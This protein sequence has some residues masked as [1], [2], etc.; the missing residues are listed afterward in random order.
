MS[1]AIDPEDLARS[2]HEAYERLAPDH[3]YSTREESRLPWADVPE[4]NK[5]LMIAVCTELGPLFRTVV[6]ECCV[7]SDALA[8]RAQELEQAIGHQDV[9]LCAICG[10]VYCSG[11][12]CIQAM[13]EDLDPEHQE[14]GEKIEALQDLVRLGRILS[15]WASPDT[16]RSTE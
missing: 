6:H 4:V 5:A 7:E 13:V 10:D 3:G 11:A 14:C 12:Y 8:A 2:F 16:D 9:D 1:T 15:E